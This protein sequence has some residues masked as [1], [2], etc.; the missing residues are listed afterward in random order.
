MSSHLYIAIR[1]YPSDVFLKRRK[2]RFPI[3]AWYENHLASPALTLLIVL[4]VLGLL[5]VLNVLNVGP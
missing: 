5:N 1:S 4:G 3:P 2:I